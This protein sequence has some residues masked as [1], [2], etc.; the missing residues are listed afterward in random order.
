MSKGLMFT[1]AYTFSKSMNDTEVYGYGAGT[2]DYFNRKLDKSLA[3]LDQP[4]TL[5][6]SYIYELPFGPGQKY[7]AQGVTSKIL[8]GWKITGMQIYAS[9]T[10]LGF[11]INNN[12]PI[13][14]A[15][16]R[17]D[18]VSSNLRSS[19]SANAFDPAKD[20]WLNPG[21]FAI[22]AAYT[23]GNAPRNTWARSPAFMQESLG[24]L[25]DTKWGERFNWQ[26]RVESSNPLN[27]VVFGGPVS[28]F[29]SGSF[30][31]ITSAR[32]SRSLTLGTK[33]YF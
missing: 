11:N 21:A 7:L 18:I 9:G 30:G 5:S 20:L 10:P 25:K 31:K 1:L 4:H 22:P 19:V 8:G 12:L 26:L 27:R 28:N 16:Q 13:G 17:P 14:N 33:F 32:G 6:L 24:L 29:S 23:F 15:S 2:M 3:S